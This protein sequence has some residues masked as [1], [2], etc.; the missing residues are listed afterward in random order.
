LDYIFCK[1]R[2]LFPFS[3]DHGTFEKIPVGLNNTTI[4]AK[5]GVKF[6]PIT[7]QIVPTKTPLAIRLFSTSSTK[8]QRFGIIPA[9]PLSL[10]MLS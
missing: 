1:F 6:S 8:S 4:G 10:I 5:H 2:G 9:T 3:L 7:T